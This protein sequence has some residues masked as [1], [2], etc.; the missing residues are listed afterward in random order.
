MK[1]DQ[2]LN[3]M[4]LKIYMVYLGFFGIYLIHI[5][6]LLNFF[7]VN[8]VGIYSSKLNKYFIII[9]VASDPLTTIKDSS[10]AGPVTL[11]ILNLT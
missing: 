11:Y 7:H 4:V 9:L 3:P 10:F 2:L 1:V 6:F 5:I 8:T